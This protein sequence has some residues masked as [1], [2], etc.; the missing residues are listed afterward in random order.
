MSVSGAGLG[1]LDQ[2]RFRALFC[3]ACGSSVVSSTCVLSSASFVTVRTC[4]GGR[5]PPASM[6][7]EP[8][9]PRRRAALPHPRRL[10]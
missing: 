9:S 10:S 6:R 3:S 2:Q 8:T 1:D 5:G 7:E 4:A